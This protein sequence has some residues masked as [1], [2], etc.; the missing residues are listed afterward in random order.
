MVP[1]SR[2]NKDYNLSGKNGTLTKYIDFSAINDA[3]I[4][5]KRLQLI[6]YIALDMDGTIYKGSNLYPFT[7]PFLETLKSLNIKY[8]FL[9]NNPSKATADYLRHL[10]EMGIHAHEN[11]MLTSARATIDYIKYAFP[12]FKN[13]FILGTPSMISEFEAEGFIS[14]DSGSTPDA[15][16]VSFDKSLVYQ[17]LC[18]AAYWVSL[19]LPYIAT[20]PDRVC[21]TD[22]PLVLVDCGAICACIEYAVNRKPDIIIGKPDPRMLEGVLKKNNL[23]PSEVAMCGDRIYTDVRTAYNA[24]ALSVLVLSGEATL[25][26]TKKSELKPDVIVND[27]GIFGEM[28]KYARGQ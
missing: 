20:N 17:R 9:T 18:Q 22:L 6:K 27:L 3:E 8:S 28:L 5:F 19:G 24:G 4:L 10:N 13:L 14:V 11:E 26:D 15:V 23:L 7:I 12:Q 16:I 21:P 2:E 1:Y 25:E